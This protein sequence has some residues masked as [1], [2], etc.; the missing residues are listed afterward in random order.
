MVV[1]APVGA[2]FTCRKFSQMNDPNGFQCCERTYVCISQLRQLNYLYLKMTMYASGEPQMM[3]L[4]VG[5]L[6]AEKAVQDA[7]VDNL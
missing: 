2:Y 4:C 5:T 3:S 6:E 1:T 7:E